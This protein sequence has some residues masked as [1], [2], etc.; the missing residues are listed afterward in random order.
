MRPSM[1]PSMQPTTEPSQQ[2]SGRLTHF[3]HHTLSSSFLPLRDYS[4]LSVTPTT[5][6]KKTMA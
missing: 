2:P 1:Q 6:C 3:N 5:P 4:L